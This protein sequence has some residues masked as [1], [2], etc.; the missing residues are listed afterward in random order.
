MVATF[1]VTKAR[2]FQRGRGLRTP[3]AR[4]ELTQRQ[5]GRPVLMAQ[6]LRSPPPPRRAGA[7]G[8][9]QSGHPARISPGPPRPPH[10]PIMPHG[11]PSCPRSPAVQQP[12]GTRRAHT[13]SPGRL[14]C[15]PVCCV[16][17]CPL[18]GTARPAHGLADGGSVGRGGGRAPAVLEV[19]AGVEA[20]AGGGS[21]AG[22]P[23]MPSWPA[24]RLW[25][26]LRRSPGR[27]FPEAWLSSALVMTCRP[28]AED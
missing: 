2:I 25:S 9:L 12:P 15:R 7:A 17:W 5:R 3:P 24:S 4:P 20:W 1:F 23:E 19:R 8:Q 26:E 18:P 6:L 22:R 27:V 13:C 28:Q 21:L 14:A 16:A 11:H 10:L